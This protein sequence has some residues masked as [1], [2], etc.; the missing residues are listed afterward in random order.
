MARYNRTI[1]F[2]IGELKFAWNEKK[3]REN[4]RKHG[5]TFEEVASCWLDP[6]GAE[7]YDEEHTTEEPRWFYMGVSK[8]SRLLICWFTERETIHEETIRIIGARKVNA[9]ERQRYEERIAR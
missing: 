9:S 5:V 1:R 2:Q 7:F 8:F 4:E 6:F 3:A